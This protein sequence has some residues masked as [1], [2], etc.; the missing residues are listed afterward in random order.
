MSLGNLVE[1]T[2]IGPALQ[3]QFKDGSDMVYPAEGVQKQ[4]SLH[5]DTVETIKE[6]KLHTIIEK[7][8]NTCQLITRSY[9]RESSS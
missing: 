2:V 9:I 3:Q 7:E 1:S 5:Q 4:V 8:C 6:T